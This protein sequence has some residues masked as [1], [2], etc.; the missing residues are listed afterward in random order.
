MQLNQTTKWILWRHTN[1]LK[2]PDVECD[3]TT[4]TLKNIGYFDVIN[5]SKV[6]GLK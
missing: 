3:F 5:E 2:V 1:D 4:T 6:D